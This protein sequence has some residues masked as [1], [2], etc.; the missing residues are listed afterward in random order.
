MKVII[1]K[2]VL[3]L[4]IILKELK[5]NL[6]KLKN[7]T[8]FIGILILTV[9]LS[10]NSQAQFKFSAGIES[11]LA[12]ET[13]FGLM[14][15]GSIGGEYSMGTKTSFTT[16]IG[17]IINSVDKPAGFDKYSFTFL[18]IQAGYKY[19]FK[20]NESGIYIHGQFG[21]HVAMSSVKYTY[22][23][24]RYDPNTFQL[25]TEEE[26]VSDSDSS[27]NLSFALGGGYKINEHIDLGI[28]YNVIS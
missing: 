22:T 24:Y 3:L 23:T 18:P 19:Y 28:R 2:L 16:Q 25:I 14:Y 10:K 26:T 4:E 7:I 20:S 21:I 11:G 6:T 17:Y 27:T 1:L 5:S 9:F 12:L 13:G 15:G 8:K